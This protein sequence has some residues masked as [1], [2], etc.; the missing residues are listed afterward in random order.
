MMDRI[1]PT[2]SPRRVILATLLAVSVGAVW[3]AMLVGPSPS[4]PLAD[5]TASPAAA[6]T[7]P[8]VELPDA[9]RLLPAAPMGLRQASFPAEADAAGGP[10]I[11]APELPAAGVSERPVAPVTTQP[12][13][14]PRREGDIPLSAAET[15]VGDATSVAP[16]ESEPQAIE[17]RT[18]AEAAPVP[19]FTP[20]LT[21]FQ[22]RERSRQLEE[23]AREAD[24]HTR[25]GFELAGRGARFSARAEFVQALRLVAEGL[26]A[27]HQCVTHG[28]SLA[29]GL[30]ALDEAE[31]FV[32]R[33]SHL[34]ADL[35]LPSIIAGHR[36]RV[37]KDTSLDGVTP[38]AAV[39][40]YLTFAQQQLAAAAGAEVAGSMALHALGKLDAWL[41]PRE[42]SD[43]KIAAPRAMACYQAALL[44][45]RKNY[46]AANDLGVLLACQGR[47][48][49]ARA[50]LEHSLS[51]HPNATAWENLAAVHRQLGNRDLADRAG[52][53]A[54]TT[55]REEKQRLA[56]GGV[57]AAPKAK[58]VEPAEFA[59]S[60][61]KVPDPHRPPPT[62]RTA[63][64]AVADPSRPA[65]P[66]QAERSWPWNLLD[67]ARK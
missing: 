17:E 51:V 26:D 30:A 66:Q 64:P 39:Q 56:A 45:C 62:P 57:T 43:A 6:R 65:G 18:S 19:S 35:D 16:R 11:L 22:P 1:G 5:A 25:R 34:E 40:R 44:V 50:A 48:E 67:N 33:G 20:L 58:W 9:P 41:A 54:Q 13:P 59:E 12:C 37:L 7:L 10:A 47:P 32:P 55:L 15:R 29:D 52:K 23:V 63:T 60:Y 31:D 49:E 4:P 8:P 53:L 61:A 27:E 2:R 38:M 3:L 28:Q 46:M 21:P 14:L 24:V 36:T 42:P